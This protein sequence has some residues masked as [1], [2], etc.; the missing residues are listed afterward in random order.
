[1]DSVKSN[2]DNVRK[3]TDTGRRSFMWKVG[4]G[5]SAVLVGA[6]PA[7]ARPIISSDKK[8]KGSVDSL[9]RRVA[10]LENEKSIRKLHKTYE[11][12][13]DNGMYSDVLNMFSADAEVIFNGGVFRGRQGL[14][15]LFCECFNAGKTGRRIDQ[16]PGFQ[17]KPEQQQDRVTISSDQKSAKALFTYSIQV[18]APIDS[19]SLLVKMS[20]LHGEGI[21]KWWEGGICKVS[22]VRDNN[23][24][25]KMNKLEYRVLSAADYKP[26]KSTAK[27]MSIHPF[28]KVFPADP[29]GPDRLVS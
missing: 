2:R 9:S 11:D 12:M 4:A 29:F 13:L 22:Y 15:R 24:S 5:M 10:A 18:G 23:K 25:W 14:K 26:G 7:F 21:M 8:L 20:R 16:A 3:E 17:L 6:V 1:M 28:S 19:D 27:P